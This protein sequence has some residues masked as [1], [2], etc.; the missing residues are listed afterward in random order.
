M[1]SKKGK[2]GLIIFIVILVL[3]A[4]GALV[5]YI[6]DYQN[7]KKIE[8]AM[9]KPAL[10][11]FDKYVSVN[12]GANAYKVTLGMLREANQDGEAYN[13]KALEGCDNE[14]TYATITV[15]YNDGSVKSVEFQKKC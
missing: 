2:L 4:I 9:K 7:T 13:L 14:K 15:D 3:G 12:S 10:D 5:Y 8:T 6:H 1:E 11:Y